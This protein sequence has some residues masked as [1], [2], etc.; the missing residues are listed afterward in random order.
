MGGVERGGEALSIGQEGHV[1]D[2][3]LVGSATGD[4]LGM[5]ADKVDGC[6]DR[7]G[8]AV[9]DH[10]G[11]VA[12]EDAVNGGLR[13]ETSEGVVVAGDQRELAALDLGL[14]EIGCGEWGSNVL[15]RHGACRRSIK[16]RTYMPPW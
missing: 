8:V 2:D 12:H 11:A 14:D 4:G 6:G 9:H 3:E 15:H 1:G 10:C 16:S 13:E 5:Q 7:G